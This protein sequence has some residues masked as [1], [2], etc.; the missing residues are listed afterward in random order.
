MTRKWRKSGAGFLL[1]TKFYN[2]ANGATLLIP[3]KR[4][5]KWKGAIQTEGLVVKK[6]DNRTTKQIATRKFH[7]NKLEANLGHPREDRMRAAV[8]HLHYIIKGTPEV[9]E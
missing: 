6:Q 8:N 9:F 7:A 3:K 5:P 1:T 4:K 2:R